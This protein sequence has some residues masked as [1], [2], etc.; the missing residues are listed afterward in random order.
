MDA[1]AVKKLVNEVRKQ[2]ETDSVLGEGVSVEIVDRD[3]R[4]KWEVLNHVHRIQDE[5]VISPHSLSPTDM[6]ISNIVSEITQKE[7]RF[8]FN[9]L[10]SSEKVPE[11]EIDSLTHNNLIDAFDVYSPTILYVPFSRRGI[12][13]EEVISSA[14]SAMDNI[15][16]IS[17]DHKFKR[18]EYF[19]SGNKYLYLINRDRIKFSKLLNLPSNQTDWVPSGR[20]NSLDL[21]KDSL[22]C[23]FHPGQGTN[24]RLAI[25]SVLEQDPHIPENGAIKI[26]VSDWDQS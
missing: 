26:R 1:E 2:Y 19:P 21:D 22:Y 23:S 12:E 15:T 13:N 7:F 11:N 14:V 8:I 20:F 4:Q 18:D 24:Y 25:A 6:D 10:D 3:R 9:V 16:N 17:L 5:W